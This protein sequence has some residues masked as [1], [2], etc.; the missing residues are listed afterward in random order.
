MTKKFFFKKGPIQTMT[1]RAIWANLE[2]IMLQMH[3][4]TWCSREDKTALIQKWEHG[5]F[6]ES[7]TDSE[8]KSSLSCAGDSNIVQTSCLRH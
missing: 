1:H 5:C 7:N 6:F 4:S 8:G 3:R 2:S